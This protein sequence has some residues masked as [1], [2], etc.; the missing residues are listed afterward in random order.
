MQ[1]LFCRSTGL[2]PKSS[3]SPLTQCCVVCFSIGFEETTFPQK[4]VD[5]FSSH[6]SAVSKLYKAQAVAS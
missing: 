5:G 6:R 3:S 1:H 2:G 4:K